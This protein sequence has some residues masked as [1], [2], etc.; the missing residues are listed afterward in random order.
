MAELS[1]QLRTSRS[2]DGR[3]GTYVRISKGSQNIPHG[4]ESWLSASNA[5]TLKGTCYSPVEVPQMSLPPLIQSIQLHMESGSSSRRR[6]LSTCPTIVSVHLKIGS[7]PFVDE[8]GLT[9]YSLPLGRAGLLP[10]ILGMWYRIERNASIQLTSS[11]NP[12]FR[13]PINT[14][15]LLHQQRLPRKDLHRPKPP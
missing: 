4:N 8:R 10:Y 11:D 3:T 12:K 2:M 6:G 14:V 5:Q 15:I 7:M 13:Y 1:C 9:V